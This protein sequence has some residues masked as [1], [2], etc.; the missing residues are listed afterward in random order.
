MH[1]SNWGNSDLQGEALQSPEMEMVDFN[2]KSWWN[3]EDI[4]RVMGAGENHQFL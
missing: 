4:Y 3:L 2:G 1:S